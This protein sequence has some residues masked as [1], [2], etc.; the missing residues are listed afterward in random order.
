[1]AD[2]VAFSASRSIEA[3]LNDMLWNIEQAEDKIE[4]VERLQDFAPVSAQYHG[5]VAKRF[6]LDFIRDM[7][8]RA[9]REIGSSASKNGGIPASNLTRNTHQT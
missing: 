2:A 1:M 4:A 6:F 7:R 5:S 8:S 3:A 9:R